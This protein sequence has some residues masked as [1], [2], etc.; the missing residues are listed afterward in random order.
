MPKKHRK[1]LLISSFVF[2]L[3]ALLTEWKEVLLFD[4]LFIGLADILSS[5]HMNQLMVIITDF[6]SAT[7][8]TIGSCLVV[9]YL[10]L[11]REWPN[12][13]MLAALMIGGSGLNLGLKSIFARQRPEEIL[14]YDGFGYSFPS[15]HAMMSFIF[16]GF[17]I[18][19]T[20]QERQKSRT[21]FMFKFF[22]AILILLIGFSR[23]YL[24]VHYASNVA[25]GFALAIMLMVIG[26]I[27]KQ[28]IKRRP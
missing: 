5:D 10:L 15:N 1:L 11:R 13:I 18:Y 20:Q 19:W 23:I 12:A 22:L 3:F 16:Y 21:V 9:V 25:G 2:L 6:G 28:N 14:L 17:I 27:V 26:D 24:G 7:V 8:L 4:Q